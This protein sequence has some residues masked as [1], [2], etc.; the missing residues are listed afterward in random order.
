LRG[1]LAVRSSSTTRP[2]RQPATKTS[3]AQ[4]AMDGRAL[5]HGP[6]SLEMWSVVT[7]PGSWSQKKQRLAL[8]GGLWPQA[9]PDLDNVLKLLADALNGVV[10]IDDKQIAVMERSGKRFG[11]APRLVVRVRSLDVAQ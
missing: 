6:V 2:T 5:M 10:W 11:E 1:R 8:S 9:K 3:S 4:E 7:P